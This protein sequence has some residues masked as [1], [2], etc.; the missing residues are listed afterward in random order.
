MSQTTP[1]QNAQNNLIEA[2]EIDFDQYIRERREDCRSWNELITGSLPNRINQCELAI[3]KIDKEIDFCDEKADSIEA[4]RV[5]PPDYQIW[6]LDNYEQLLNVLYALKTW[7][8]QYQDDYEALHH[9]LS[10]RDT[11]TAE[12]IQRELEELSEYGLP[13]QDGTE[14]ELE[15]D[16]EIEDDS[17]VGSESGSEDDP[18]QS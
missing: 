15:E 9:A 17:E 5:A 13:T 12:E 8:R 6:L 16:S 2:F 11:T 3:E 4:D 1:L 14:S 18:E 7:F 10:N